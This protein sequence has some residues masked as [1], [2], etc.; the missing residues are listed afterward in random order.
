M[1]QQ[2]SRRFRAAQDAEEKEKEEERLREDFAK[3]VRAVVQGWGACWCQAFLNDAGWSSLEAFMEAQLR[4][5]WG[6]GVC[7]AGQGTLMASCAHVW[8]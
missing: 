4:Q 3:Q 6:E 5:C 8:G 2:R 7:Q 1:N